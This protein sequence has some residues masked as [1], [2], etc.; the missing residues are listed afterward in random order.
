VGYFT[1]VFQSLRDKQG[2]VTHINCVALDV[3]AQV[4]ARQKV[5]DL[6]E[7]LAASNEE[8]AASNEELTASNEEY[9]RANTALDEAQQH[10]L[11]AE[12]EWRVQERTREA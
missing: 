9:Q 1:A 4:L 7:E 11:N 5:Q 12:L 2:Q 6:N 3:T 8:L 10:R